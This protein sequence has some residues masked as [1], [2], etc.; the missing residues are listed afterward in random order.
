[1][2][3]Y[4]YL[5]PLIGFL[6]AVVFLGEHID[7]KFIFATLLIFGGVYLVTKKFARSET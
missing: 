6:L 3:V 2:A 4:I 7:L 5:Y 1:V